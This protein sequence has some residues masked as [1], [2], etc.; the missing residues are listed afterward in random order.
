VPFG[1]LVLTQGNPIPM[2]KT[3]TAAL[4]AEAILNAIPT[5]EA[6][7]RKLIL[8]SPSDFPIGDGVISEVL[9][10]H[11]ADL[12]R[13]KGKTPKQ[14]AQ[15]ISMDSEFYG[16]APPTP[17][18]QKTKVLRR[19]AYRAIDGMSDYP[20]KRD[21]VI[22]VINSLLDEQHK[23]TGESLRRLAAEI[24]AGRTDNW[25]GFP[26]WST[27]YFKKTYAKKLK[28]VP[29]KLLKMA[30]ED[31]F[32]WAVR[33]PLSEHVL[34]NDMDESYSSDGETSHVMVD[35]LILLH[36]VRRILAHVPAGRKRD[37]MIAACNANIARH[38]P[39]TGEV[40]ARLKKEAKE[41]KRADAQRKKEAKNKYV[42]SWTYYNPEKSDTGRPQH[43][44]DSYKNLHDAKN[45]LWQSYSEL[46]GEI[47]EGGGYFDSYE[48]EISIDDDAMRFTSSGLVESEQEIRTK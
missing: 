10:E 17:K 22:S 12:E 7:F 15:S 24:A 8:G 34:W 16:D 43:G 2:K 41:F 4:T 32:Y 20:H 37:D 38:T 28:S 13:Y 1:A 9:A 31:Y 5:T 19:I 36:L 23:V 42:I 47:D 48:N 39:A 33:A 26:V 6:E 46:K 29:A 14:I 35:E 18:N 44:Q 27:D 21:V 25:D 40:L 45:A 30:A 3:K 11:H